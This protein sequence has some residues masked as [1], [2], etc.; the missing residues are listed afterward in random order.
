MS[1]FKGNY[2]TP[3]EASKKLG[4]HWQTLKNWDKQG[5]IK[6]I[7]S[8]GGKRYYD[9]SDFINKIE[10]TNNINEEL[11]IENKRKK[12]CYCRVS[13]DSQK[14]ELEN[15]IKYMKDKYP[16]HEILYDIGSGINFNRHNL[17]KIINYGIKNELE[18]LAIAYKDRL[19]RIGYE[20]I[21]NILKE[22]SNTNIIIENDEIKSPEEELTTD[23]IEII[24]VFSSKL[25]GIRSYKSKKSEK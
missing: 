1:F 17:N 8:P 9:I 13:S 23:L 21:E 6:T 7:R 5:K 3:K 18:E 24:T 10:G 4:V 11:E 14:I 20:L 25:Y 19:C 12:I 2:Y 15:Q 22:Y 16:E